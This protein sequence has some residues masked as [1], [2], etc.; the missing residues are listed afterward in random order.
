[1]ILP[2][3]QNPSHMKSF[4]SI[5]AVGGSHYIEV[6]W[7]SSSP[8]E[9]KGLSLQWTDHSFENDYVLVQTHTPSNQ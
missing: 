1:M 3:K 6:T 2:P 9:I 4:M 7:E 8:S 5:V